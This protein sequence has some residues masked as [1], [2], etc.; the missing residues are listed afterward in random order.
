ML[1]K[2]GEEVH[3]NVGVTCK[4]A[5]CHKVTRMHVKSERNH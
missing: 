5:G 1:N 2:D 3:K 4:M